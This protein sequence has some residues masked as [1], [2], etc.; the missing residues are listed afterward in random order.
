[1]GLILG[2]VIGITSMC[3]LQIGRI[4]ELEKECY[5]WERE[6]KKWAVELGERKI[7]EN[8]KDCPDEDTDKCYIC[9]GGAS[10]VCNA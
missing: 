7:Q 5:Y 3:M 9:K 4:N 10:N 8:C 6:A 1:M 2:V